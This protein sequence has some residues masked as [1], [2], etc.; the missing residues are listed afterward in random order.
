MI[1][2]RLVSLRKIVRENKKHVVDQII[3]N[4]NASTCVICGTNKY[5][6]KEHVIPKWTFGAD[7]KKFFVTSINGL[8]LVLCKIWIFH[9]AKYFQISD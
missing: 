8:L 6:T 1:V 5:L 4:H 3:H 9:Q 2:Q 7:E